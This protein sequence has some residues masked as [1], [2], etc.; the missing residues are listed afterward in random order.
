MLSS[1]F[2]SQKNNENFSKQ[3]ISVGFIR[4]CTFLEKFV[5]QPFVFHKT[6]GCERNVMLLSSYSFVLKRERAEKGGL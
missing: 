4:N 1:S 3:F 6:R 5:N 2:F